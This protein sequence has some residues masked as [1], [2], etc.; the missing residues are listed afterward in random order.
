MQGQT[1]CRVCTFNV[2]ANYNAVVKILEA[3]NVTEIAIQVVTGPVLMTGN[4]QFSN[5]FG[6]TPIAS[7]SVSL[8]TGS[9]FVFQ[10]GGPQAPIDNLSF[11][12]TG[13]SCNF[14]MKM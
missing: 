7:A 2:P 11:D 4:F 8:A 9:A 10:S 13:G 3:D 14:V 6:G 5:S 1:P 12:A